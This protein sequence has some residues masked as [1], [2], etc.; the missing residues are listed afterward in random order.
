MS[1]TDT[2]P[3]WKDKPFHATG[4]IPESNK[5]STWFEDWIN[6][7]EMFERPYALCE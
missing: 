2:V 7:K 6:G 5:L 3:F 4:L 1:H